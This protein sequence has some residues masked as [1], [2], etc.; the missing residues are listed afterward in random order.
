MRLVPTSTADR[1][2]ATDLAA[3]CAVGARAAI[4]WLA[5]KQRADGLTD[6]ADAWLYAGHKGLAAFAAGGRPVEAGRLATWLARERLGRD[7][8]L[9]DGSSRAGPARGVWLYF[10]SWVAWGA[11]R[12]GRFDISLPM[13]R[14]I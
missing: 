9:G 3:R 8:D 4:D 11:H 6:G 7:G 5:A 10:N 12:A 14:F 13:S 2:R 1:E